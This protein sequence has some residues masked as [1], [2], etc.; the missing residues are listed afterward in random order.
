[1]PN[2]DLSEKEAAILTDELES[3]LEDLKTERVRT[4]KRDLHAQFLERENVLSGVITR[5]KAQR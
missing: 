1:M 2:I 5:L 3:C 4:D